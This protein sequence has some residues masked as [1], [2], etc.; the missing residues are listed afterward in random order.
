[1]HQILVV[2]SNFSNL[3]DANRIAEALLN[4]KLIACTNAWPIRSQYHWDGKDMA[5]SEIRMEFK[6][7][8]ACKLELLD[9]LKANHPYELPYIEM[10]YRQVDEA[11]AHWVSNAIL[12]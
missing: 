3:A 6:T 8:E 9:F 12:T 10:A 7:S 5:D 11:Y 1:M 4:K 2:S